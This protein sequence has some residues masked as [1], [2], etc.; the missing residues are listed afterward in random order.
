MLVEVHTPDTAMD[1]KLCR[2][3]KFELTAGTYMPVRN[4]SNRNVK[5]YLKKK[6]A[7]D[8]IFITTAAAAIAKQDVFF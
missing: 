2:L 7:A 1:C 5:S 8:F 3:C 4:Q 6:K